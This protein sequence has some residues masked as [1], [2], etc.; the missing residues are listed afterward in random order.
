LITLHSFE[1]FLEKKKHFLEHKTS[2]KSGC[3]KYRF[4]D[5]TEIQ[6][7]NLK[8]ERLVDSGVEI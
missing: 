4:S 5:F 7:K 1:Q 2:L 3:P 6:I 8:L